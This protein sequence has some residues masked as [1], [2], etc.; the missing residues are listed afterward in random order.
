MSIPLDRLYHYIESVAQEVYGDTLIYLFY[1][2]G[3][4]NIKDLTGLIGKNLSTWNSGPLHPHVFCNDQEILNYEFYQDIDVGLLKGN[5]KLKAQLKESSVKMPDYNLRI[6]AW[7]I[8]DHCIILHSELRSSEV[9]R[10]K[11]NYFIP[12]YYW[13]HALLALDWF[14]FAKHIVPVKNTDTQLFLIY[15]RAWSGT[16]EY[17][18]KFA[19]WLIENDLVDCCQITCNQIDPNLNVSYANHNFNN[20]AWKP[21]HQLENYFNSNPT[22]SCSS[23]DF[24][25]DDYSNTDFEVV[26]ETI[27]D[28]S[29]LHLTEKTLRPIA[30]SQPFLLVGT[31]GSL[32]YL[33]SYG[34]ETFAD[35]IDESYDL[36]IDPAQRLKAV[37]D[38]MNHIRSWTPEQ[39][40]NNMQK[41]QEIASRNRQHF[42]SDAFFNRI[43]NE[44]KQNLSDGLSELVE[45]NT[46]QR[47]FNLRKSLSQ[48]SK[49]KS[50][51]TNSDERRSRQD[52]A[53]Y[54][55]QARYYYNKH[56]QTL[57]K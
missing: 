28:D 26:L 37:I 40:K 14:R 8:Y 51:L 16:R 53:Y 24:V 34:F 9:D 45:L 22:E 33:R 30:C 47:F 44:L 43:V 29:R 5:P 32:E 35:V 3:S 36:I 31:H 27:F 18:L 13:S 1:P 21:T 39:R 25:I 56:S 41:L 52:I 23:A 7:D 10:Y 46:G 4:K 17:R 42:F 12:V 57:N 19:D 15:N 54:V 20:S 48:D 38:S 6:D 2:Y 50:I 49:L 11:K 55:Q